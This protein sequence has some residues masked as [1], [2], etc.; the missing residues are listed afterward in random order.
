M[1]ILRKPLLPFSAVGK[2]TYLVAIG[3]S[4]RTNV[5]TISN[6][7]KKYDFQREC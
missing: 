7:I 6:F 2:W 4:V 3:F 1:Y 5:D